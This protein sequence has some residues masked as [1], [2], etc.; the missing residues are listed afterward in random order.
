MADT[1]H[2]M[3]EIVTEKALNEYD[4]VSIQDMWDA[5]QEEEKDLEAHRNE[6]LIAFDGRQHQELV[7]ATGGN[8]DPNNN[9]GE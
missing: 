7:I 4:P 9:E 3:A 1:I 6:M 2:E 8:P 5:E